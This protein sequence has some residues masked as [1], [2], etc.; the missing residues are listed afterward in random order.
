MMEPIEIESVFPNLP[1]LTVGQ[2]QKVVGC[3]VVRLSLHVGGI[4][5]RVHRVN[6]HIGPKRIANL[7][8]ATIVDPGHH[9]S[10]SPCAEN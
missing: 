5:R 9:F 7:R 8:D 2:T 6:G 1:D 4:V 10:P 3:R